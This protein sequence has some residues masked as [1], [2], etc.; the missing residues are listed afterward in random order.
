MSVADADTITILPLVKTD[1]RAW[2]LMPALLERVRS[3]CERYDTDSAPGYLAQ[4]VVEHFVAEPEDKLP[5]RAL[6]ALQGETM[7]GHLLVEVSQWSGRT[8]ATIT[9]LEA[10]VAI[11][12]QQMID[13]FEQIAWWA[14][15]KG[16]SILRVL[17]V[18]NDEHAAARIR[19][20]RT[21]YGLQPSRVVMNKEIA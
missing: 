17:A 16:A 12:R 19:M 18:V 3:F 7:V 9:Q 13:A 10:D 14:K 4:V 11:P 21:V 20:F 2:A 5:V 15:H 6:V 1:P 8:Y